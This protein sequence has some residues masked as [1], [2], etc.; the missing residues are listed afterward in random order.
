MKQVFSKACSHTGTLKEGARRPV[1]RR[2]LAIPLN[3]TAMTGKS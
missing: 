1:K 2:M 3:P